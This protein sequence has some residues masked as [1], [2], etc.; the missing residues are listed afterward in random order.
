MFVS[1]QTKPILPLKRAFD[2]V[3]K[4]PEKKDNVIKHI[5]HPCGSASAWEK[6]RKMFLLHAES[7]RIPFPKL[8]EATYVENQHQI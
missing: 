4:N 5:Q 8:V 6:T 3:A 7:Q 2:P 1:K